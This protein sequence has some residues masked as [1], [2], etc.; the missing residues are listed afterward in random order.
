MQF[1]DVLTQLV[2]A[3]LWVVL[4]LTFMFTMLMLTAAYLTHS[5]TL[6]VEAFHA[7]YNLFTLFGAILAIKVCSMH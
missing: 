2:I 7:M 4:L 5:L 6:R 1:Q 3:K